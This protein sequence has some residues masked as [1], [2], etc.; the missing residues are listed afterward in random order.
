MTGSDREKEI[1]Q[2]LTNHGVLRLQ[3]GLVS[4]H[5]WGRISDQSL[6]INR[7]LVVEFERLHNFSDLL[8]LANHSTMKVATQFGLKGNF[9]DEFSTGKVEKP[10]DIDSIIIEGWNAPYELPYT[11]P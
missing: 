7:A 10:L 6:R 3:D 9:I 11:L 4:P 8:H 5:M 1:L 2:G